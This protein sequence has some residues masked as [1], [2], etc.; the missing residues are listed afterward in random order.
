M[1]AQGLTSLRADPVDAIQKHDVQHYQ[2]EDNVRPVEGAVKYVRKTVG[3]EQGVFDAEIVQ[4]T[5]V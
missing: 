5:N 1:E 3:Y 2:G 4:S